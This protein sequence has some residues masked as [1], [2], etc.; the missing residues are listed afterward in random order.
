M[1]TINTLNNLKQNGYTNLDCNSNYDNKVCISQKDEVIMDNHDKGIFD[2][3]T[4]CGSPRLYPKN[5]DTVL[6]WDM[7][8]V[9]LCKDCLNAIEM[10]N[11]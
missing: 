7:N 1:E 6:K 8:F 4:F 2:E 9:E 3:F 10:E 11:K 5:I